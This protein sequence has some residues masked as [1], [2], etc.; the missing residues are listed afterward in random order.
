M[1]YHWAQ[2]DGAIVNQYVWHQHFNGSPDKAA[3]V[4]RMHMWESIIET[5]QA[6]MDPIPMYEDEPGLEER[7]R[8]FMGG[9]NAEKPED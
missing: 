3:T 1:T 6:A 2:G 9:E 4:I 7:M 5:M 8:A